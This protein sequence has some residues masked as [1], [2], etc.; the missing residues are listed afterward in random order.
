MEEIIKNL[1]IDLFN[2]IQSAA[3][4][5]RIQFA[6]TAIIHFI[7]PPLTIGL[8]LFVAVIETVYAFTKNEKYRIMTKFWG[9]LFLINFAVGVV[10]GIVME[11]EF[12]MNWARFS[13]YVGDIFG[14]PLAIEVLLAFFMESVFIGLW[15]FGWDKFHRGVHA[16]FIWLVSIGTIASSLWIL[17]ANAFMQ[18]P[19]GFVVRNG[20]A[21]LVDFLAILTT[22][23]VSLQFW[24]TLFASFCTAAFFIIGICAYHFWRKSND[25]EV[26]KTSF[27]LASLYGLIGMVGVLWYG[28]FMADHIIEA[29]PMKM[30][31]MEA[32]WE[33]QDPAP[34]GLFVITDQKQNKNY[35]KLEIPYG[36]SLIAYGKLSGPI[37]GAND[38]QRKYEEQYGKGNYI[39]PVFITFYA[40]RA[41][42]GAGTLMLLIAIFIFV[43]TFIW[44]KYNYSAWFLW[45]LVF[46]ITLPYVA[47]ITGWIVTEV[48]R[49]PWM[50]QG[51]M[52]TQNATSQSVSCID[53][54]ISLIVLGTFFGILALVDIYFLWKFSTA[55]TFDFR[56]Q[57]EEKK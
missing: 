4:M 14:V 52:L 38:I 39:P 3:F 41:M 56:K 55:G 15:I 1:V 47:N 20:R 43:R 45:L 11:F 50:V 21:E 22:P 57:Q 23:Q 19:A 48:G 37:V 24:H 18:E 36:F 28:H 51:L 16:L 5:A 49:Q 25:I 13:S 33:T 30:A 40:F 8:S 10:T 17:V 46:C 27:K 2:N 54:W 29:Q 26:Y 6:V 12:G 53:I 34:E 42:V 35:F 31:A 7:F 44:G 9:R 32:A